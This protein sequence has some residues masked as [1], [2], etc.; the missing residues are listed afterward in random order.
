M[1]IHLTGILV[2]I[3]NNFHGLGKEKCFWVRN[4]GQEQNILQNVPTTHC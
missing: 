4:R 1:Y 2:V 3:E